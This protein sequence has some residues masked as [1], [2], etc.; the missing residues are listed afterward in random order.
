MG[1]EP[2]IRGTRGSGTVFLAGCPLHCLFCQNFDTSHEDTGR[3]VTTRQFVSLLRRLVEDGCHNLNFVTPSH[4]TAAILA[5]LQALVEE[6]GGTYPPVVWNC[7]GYESPEALSLL[8]GVVDI[9]MPDLKFLDSNA[10]TQLLSAPDYP[11]IA[12][13]ALAEMYRQVGPVQL[14]PDGVLRRGVL[15]RHLVMP[16]MVADTLRILEHVA[17]TYGPSV[18]VNV[19][20]QYRPCGYA[21]RYPAINRTPTF[22]ELAEATSHARSL[23]LQLA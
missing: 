9:Y 22:D 13:A 17:A 7:G 2:M 5:A 10:S 11:E 3:E 21:S 23:G 6:E 19:M 20:G 18:A 14:G 16:G 15:I 4:H 8:D 1:E 12:V